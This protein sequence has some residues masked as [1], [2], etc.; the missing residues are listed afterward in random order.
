LLLIL[1][2]LSAR[3]VDSG[4]FFAAIRDDICRKVL[5]HSPGHPK[6]RTHILDIDPVLA[7]GH[8]LSLRLNPVR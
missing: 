1:D 3:L 4:G 8:L 7:A 2:S 6:L 5:N